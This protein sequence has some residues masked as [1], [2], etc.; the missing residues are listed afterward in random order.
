MA[1]TLDSPDIMEGSNTPPLLAGEVGRGWLNSCI[2]F[3]KYYR[4]TKGK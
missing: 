3:T 1:V 4:L 2:S